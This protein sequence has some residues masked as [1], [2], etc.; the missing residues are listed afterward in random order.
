MQD[1]MKEM[2]LNRLS[3]LTF[4]ISTQLINNFLWRFMILLVTSKWA[5]GNWIHSFLLA[6]KLS[7]VIPSVCLC[8][9]FFFEL[10]KYEHIKNR[11]TFRIFWFCSHS[12]MSNYWI[13]RTVRLVILWCFWW[14][15]VLSKLRIFTDISARDWPQIIRRDFKTN[16]LNT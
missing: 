2:H 14:T 12:F 5:S 9:F 13:W 15:W 6:S 7:I 8:F 3:R 4:N 16:K 10:S 1:A 11:Q